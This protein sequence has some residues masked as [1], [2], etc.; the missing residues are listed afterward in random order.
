MLVYPLRIPQE[1]LVGDLS[2]GRANDN[3]VYRLVPVAR[4]FVEFQHHSVMPVSTELR[5]VATFPIQYLA[6]IP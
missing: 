4:A 3:M 2:S 6:P 1:I 5:I